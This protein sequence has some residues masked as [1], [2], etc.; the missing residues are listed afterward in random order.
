[1]L[2]CHSVQW[3]QK[4]TG[5]ACTTAMRFNAPQAMRALSRFRSIALMRCSLSAIALSTFLAIAPL[6]QPTWA[7]TDQMMLE[8]SLSANADAQKTLRQAE[9]MVSATLEQRFSQDATLSALEVVILGNRDGQIVPMLTTVVSR[10]QWD[11]NP[12]V[13]LWT[14]YANSLS[15]LLFYPSRPSEAIA[16][17]PP[18]PQAARQPQP[19]RR[20]FDLPI[21]QIEQAYDSGRLSPRQLNDWVDLLD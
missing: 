4:A 3:S 10:E 6:A 15:A 20:S 1:M 12:Q 21:V 2:F 11:T 19:P 18:Q 9:Q 17:R 14:T 13:E 5:V 7:T 8:L 16:S